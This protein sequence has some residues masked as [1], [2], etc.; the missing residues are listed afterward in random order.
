MCLCVCV[1]TLKVNYVYLPKV[2]VEPERYHRFQHPQPGLGA[3]RQ[4]GQAHLASVSQGTSWLLLG[5]SSH[6]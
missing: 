4:A 5:K 1:N 3:Y 2:C 6:F